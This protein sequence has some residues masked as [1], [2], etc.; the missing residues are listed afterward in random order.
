[1]HLGKGKEKLCMHL[2]NSEDNNCLCITIN[3]KRISFMHLGKSK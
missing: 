2:G 3:V 1:M